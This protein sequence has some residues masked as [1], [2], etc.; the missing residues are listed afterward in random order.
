MPH[1]SN[2]PDPRE[3]GISALLRAR[4]LREVQKAY[5]SI[6]ES[7]FAGSLR[8]PTLEWARDQRHLG[9]WSQ[10]NRTIQLSAQLAGGPWGIL[11]EVLKHEM[12]HQFVSEV[13]QAETEAPHG[14]VFRRVCEERGIDPSAQGMPRSSTEFDTPGSRVLERIARLLSLAGSDNHHEAEA[15]MAAARRLMLK[16][17]IEEPPLPHSG[18]SFRHLGKPT[19]RR[20]AWQRTLANIL[21]EYFFVE[22]IIVP[23]FDVSNGKS[24]SVVEICGTPENLE[25]ASYAHDFLERAADELWRNRKKSLGSESGGRNAFLL[26]VMTGFR[27]KLALGRDKDQAEGLLWLGDPHLGQYF[28]RRH[29][30]I[31]SVSGRGVRKDGAFEAGQEAGGGLVLRRGIAEGPSGQGPRLLRG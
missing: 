15:A 7:L 1:P 13:L 11:V 30:F 14:S 17:N 5:H 25:V 6:N 18:Y 22:V 8:P 2:Q 21:A 24:A 12:A 10:T 3:A 27:K 19:Q 29:P 20:Q 4:V 31:R 16:H 26:G 28:R 23:V 9:V